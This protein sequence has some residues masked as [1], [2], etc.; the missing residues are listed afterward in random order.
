MDGDTWLK[1]I[2]FQTKS[3]PMLP[4]P[5]A[6]VSPA[7]KS[8]ESSTKIDQTVAVS[9]TSSPAGEE[10]ELD[11]NFV[12]NTPETLKVL[13]GDHLLIFRKRG[14][15]NWERKLRI[16]GEIVNVAADLGPETN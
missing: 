5:P 3:S 14:Y 9:I 13:P 6:P 16:T 2:A 12:G 10:I 11:G 4:A 8:S 15:K 1:D 7:P